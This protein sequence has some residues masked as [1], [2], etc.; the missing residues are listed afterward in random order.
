MIGIGLVGSV[1]AKNLHQ[2]GF[3]VVGH[4]IVHERARVVE[5]SGGIAVQVP[6][7][8]AE[9][10]N[11][12]VL[13]L[14]TSSIVRDV[15]WGRDGIA[16]AANKPGVIIDTSTSLPGEVVKIGQELQEINV[17]YLDAPIS[18]SS[19]QIARREGV[20]LVGG[21][22]KTFDDVRDIFKALANT[23]IHVGPQGAGSKA[24]LAINLVLGLNRASMAEG[25]LFAESIGI[26]PATAL[27]LFKATA[28]YSAVMDVKGERMVTRNFTEP[29]ARLSQHAKDVGLIH[30]LAREQ[31]CSLPFTELHR[32]V[33]QA[34]IN[35]GDGDLDNSA[36]LRAIQAFKQQASREDER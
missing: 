24:K 31:G 15:I 20:F 35:E 11:V 28:A 10:C 30:Q 29:E 3:E 6:K 13:S 17:A 5:D 19:K 18:G 33:L 22:E 27:G 32:T 34:F 25:I 8:V 14:M 26:E 12:I 7:E 4:D 36:I 16:S 9:R 23:A 1:L 21:N 2:G